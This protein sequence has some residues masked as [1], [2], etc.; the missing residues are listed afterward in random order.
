MRKV[1]F[2]IKFIFKMIHIALKRI[3]YSLN[4][5][6]FSEKEKENYLYNLE[7]DW[8]NAT[9]R[10][11]GL[12]VEAIGIENLIEDTCLYISNHQSMLDIPL[13]MSNLNSA[14]GAIGK[15]ELKKVPVVSFWMEELGSVYMDRE[16][17]REGLKAIL[18][19]VDKLKGGRSM[20][21]FPEGTRSKDGHL[22]EFKK[23]SLKLA[24]KANVP[25]MPITV[26]GTYKGL[27][28]KPG[29][30]KAKIIFH[31]PI[32]MEGLSK[33]EKNN[34]SYTCMEIIEEPIKNIN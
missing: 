31:K 19:A 12:K 15:I 2:A 10:Y 11:S 9:I 24:V 23:G 6:K 22:N 13:I 4:K 30:M 34:L 25:V 3:T 28:G 5:N 8:A 32:Y 14:V 1:G 20:L 16:N 21:L 17:G 26:D 7:N 27:E 29:D 33:E 18:M